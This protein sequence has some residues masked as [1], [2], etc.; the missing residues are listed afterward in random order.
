[1]LAEWD[2]HLFCPSG[3]A[4]FDAPQDDVTHKAF[5]CLHWFICRGSC[6]GL[7]AIILFI[8]NSTKQSSGF[9]AKG[10]NPYVPL[11]GLGFS[12]LPLSA[13]SL[14]SPFLPLHHPPVQF[15]ISLPTGPVVQPM[16]P[17]F[18]TSLSPPP[19]ISVV[20]MVC[21]L[22]HTDS[23]LYSR[24]ISLCLKI[25]F[26]TSF[27]CSF[28]QHP[29]LPLSL[30]LFLSHI[31]ANTHPSLR[32]LTS[33]DQQGTTTRVTA[34]IPLHLLKDSPFPYLITQELCNSQYL[35]HTLQYPLFAVDSYNVD[36]YLGTWSPEPVNG[37]CL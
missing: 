28:I 21:V 37:K 27:E 1:M 31:T 24:L 4:V 13:Q 30:K 11:L 3:S 34:S 35:P 20:M 18:S 33:P 2:N 25:N 16:L 5:P 17:S 14:I 22:F 15:Q 9:L 29:N 36:Y 12:N 8:H 19:E 10:E 26:R 23:L 7:E 32:H 6:L